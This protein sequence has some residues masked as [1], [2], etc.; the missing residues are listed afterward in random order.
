MSHKQQRRSPVTPPQ[1][2]QK[3]LRVPPF[4]EVIRHIFLAWLFCAFWEYILLP[5]QLLG[6]HHLNG[7]A[8]MSMPRLLIG[9][10][11]LS[12]GLCVLSRFFDITF[13]ER[14]AIPCV[15]TLY[16][17]AVMHGLQNDAFLLLCA[18]VVGIM[19]CYVIWGHQPSQSLKKPTKKV[20]WVFPI[21]V[22]LI[23]ACF[24]AIVSIWTVNRLRAYWAP[25]FDFG[26]FSQMFHNMNETGLP[27]TTIERGKLLSHFDVHISPIYYLLLPI[28]RLFPYNA[29]LQV[30]QAVILAS[31]VIPLWL[32]GKR[33]NLSGAPRTLVC[34]ILLLYPATAG[35]AAYDIHENCFLLPLVL[36]LMY[37]LDRESIWLTAIFAIL[38]LMV[39]EDAAVYV[40]VAGLYQIMRSALGKQKI[41]PLAL[42]AGI[43]ALSVAWFLLAT[44]HLATRGDGV[45]TYRYQN[46]M[47]DGS[48]SL[49]SV[50]KAV[51]LCPMK[52]LYE[53]VDAEKLPYIG[54]TLLPLLGLPL[55]TRKYDRYLLLIPYILL[56][57]MSDYTFQHNILFQYNFGSA[58]FLLYLTAVNLADLK[59]EIPQTVI[60]TVALCI[61]CLFFKDLIMT[62]CE[63]TTKAY[64]E[65]QEYYDGLTDALSIIPDDASVA[66]HTT[67]VAPL[68]D[69]AVIYDIHNYC[70]SDTFLRCDYVVLKKNC[71]YG[72]YNTDVIN[73]D[74]IIE[75]LEENGYRQV[76]KYG[77]TVI[78]CKPNQ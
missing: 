58:A 68:A 55:V 44:H 9:T 19:V 3:R 48:D 78:Y 36:W 11:L 62:E 39:K 15:F 73:V 46:F 49:F 1:P 51:I 12:A 14:L 61:S 76:K 25:A 59:W 42:G 10:G 34:V 63:N 56:N 31:A 67:Y 30:L 43:L 37:A 65:N 35:G 20:H 5:S 28:Y 21:L 7:I 33:H 74:H 77:S 24:I 38:T 22:A 18:L 40:A 52:M 53:C 27:M 17:A 66:A 26:I 8:A 4:G 54:Q 29:T 13:W 16:A 47:Y 72:L 23:A 71:T 2:E 32:I 75:I 6:M 45:M 50:I 41:L 70:P 60:A 69:R 57:L 64:T